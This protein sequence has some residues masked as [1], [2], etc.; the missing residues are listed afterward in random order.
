MIWKNTP[1]LELL[2]ASGQHTLV[3]HLAINFTDFGDDYMKA[4]M[5]VD[6]RTVQ[7]VRLLHGGA[8]V[9]LAETMGSV[10][11]VFCLENPATHTVVGVEINA[12]HLNS[13]KEGDTVTAVVRPIKVG[14]SMHVWEIKITR[15]DGKLVCVSRITIAVVERRGGGKSS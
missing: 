15:G 13:A 14:R 7:P 1:T 11:S 6:H 2:N 4:T 9:A 5:P 3:D 10:A 12:N 8:S